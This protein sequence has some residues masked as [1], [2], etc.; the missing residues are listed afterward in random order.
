MQ[1][2]GRTPLKDSVGECGHFCYEDNMGRSDTIWMKIPKMVQ[3]FES[4]NSSYSQ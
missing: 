1:P 3:A 4:Q 2:D